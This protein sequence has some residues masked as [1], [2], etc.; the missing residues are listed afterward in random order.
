MADLR[1]SQLPELFSSGITQTAEFAVAQDGTT[2]K[3][4]QGQLKS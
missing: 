1:I 4:K 3:I 2:F